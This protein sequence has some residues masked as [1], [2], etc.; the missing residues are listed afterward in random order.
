MTSSPPRRGVIVL[1]PLLLWLNV[2]SP[3]I[4]GTAHGA[5]REDPQFKR[6]VTTCNDGSRTVTHDD[7]PFK[8]WRTD[9]VKPGKA[10]ETAAKRAP[11]R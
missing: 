6:L 4:A 7:E 11:H 3:A 1:L 9:I 8:R 2:M 10:G 5:T